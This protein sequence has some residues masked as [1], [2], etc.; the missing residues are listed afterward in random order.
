MKRVVILKGEGAN[1]HTLYG[2]FKMTEVDFS[3]F[4]VNE[5]GVLRH[6][7]PTQQYSNEHKPLSIEKGLW[8]QGK[9]VEYN[10]FNRE[11]TQVWD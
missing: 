6:E 1:Q 11:V 5:R 3:E 9:Q 10:P 7:T 8:V 4:T 2:D